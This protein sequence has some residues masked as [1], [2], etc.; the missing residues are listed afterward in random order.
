MKNRFVAIRD[1]GREGCGK[2]VGV[3][4][5]GLYE[6]SLD[7]SS[8]VYLDFICDYASYDTAL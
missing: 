7:D 4:V 3:V 6:Q 5:K 8:L 2:K 1:S